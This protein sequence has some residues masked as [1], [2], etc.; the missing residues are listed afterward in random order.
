MAEEFYTNVERFL[1]L[2]SGTKK[3]RKATSNV[4]RENGDFGTLEGINALLKD[5]ITVLKIPN[6][7]Y[8]MDPEIGVGIHRDIFKP[9]DT[10]TQNELSQK[11]DYCL[12]RY[13]EDDKS[14][15]TFDIQFFRDKKGFRINFHIKYD[16]G[17]KKETSVDIDE[18]FMRSLE[19][20]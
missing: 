10:V 1:K 11:I 7:S 8:Y 4:I 20:D 19:E 14:D 17:S 2:K 5:L 9:V 3:K 12:T 15:V 16:D 6:S 13:V 18:Q